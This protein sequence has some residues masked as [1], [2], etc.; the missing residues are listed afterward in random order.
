M[1][2]PVLT[3]LEVARQFGIRFLEAKR[4]LGVLDFG[5][6][7]QYAL[8]L[9]WNFPGNQ[10]TALARSVR[11][12]LRFV[13]V[14][15]YQDI[16]VAQ[17][18]IIAALARDGAEAN[19]F[20]VGD[21]KQSIYRFRLAAP[22][23]FQGY[24]RAWS[25]GAERVIPLSENFRSREAILDFVNPVF[26]LLMRQELG[27][28]AYDDDARLRFGAPQ[29]REILSRQPG[30]TPRVQLHVLLRETANSPEEPAED[31]PAG[32]LE[33]AAREA[34]LVALQLRRFRESGTQVWDEAQ[35]LLRYCD[36]LIDGQYVEHLNDGNGL[37]GSS[38][39]RFH[40]LTDR[41]LPFQ[42]EITGRRTGLEIHLLD[43]GALMAGIPSPSFHW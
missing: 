26:A 43:D 35:E 37:R 1:R 18:R 21:V 3:L 17:D 40:F 28:V 33:A 41:L 8:R 23:I 15:E 34:R 2:Q 19:R 6:L 36:L 39:Q 11:E 29:Q 20:L 7:E 32:E 25:T 12:Q 9:L 42:E 24:A 22:R 27:G 16:N 14:D 4:A 10:P 31:D 30:H 38:N 5:D 13:F